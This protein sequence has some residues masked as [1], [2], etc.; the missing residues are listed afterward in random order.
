M[1]D[2]HTHIIPG[3]DDGPSHMEESVKMC[4]EAV[5]SGISHV[6]LTPHL[7]PGVYTKVISCGDTLLKGLMEVLRERSIDLELSLSAE[8]EAFPE[9]VRWVT[10]GKIP[11]FPCGTRMLLEFPLFAVP[12]WFEHIVGDLVSEGITPILAHPER[13][14]SF[15]SILEKLAD[16]GV[17]IQINAG[18]V[19]GIWGERVKNTA[20]FL[21]EEGF[22]K[23]LASDCHDSK[24]R[25]PRLLLKAR[26]IVAKRFGEDAARFLTDKNPR[27]LL[28]H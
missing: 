3:V 1:V 22:A 19:V 18:S 6:I 16:F 10:D 15:R 8:V 12:S 11:L 23:Y 14:P 5:T 7:I 28:G 17:E 24:V 13:N 20:F 25:T 4:L 26:N 9:V 21:I 27:K 2:I